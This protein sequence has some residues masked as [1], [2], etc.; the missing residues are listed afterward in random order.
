MA[1]YAELYELRQ[2]PDLL[3]RTVIACVVAAEI[4]RTDA[5]AG[6][7][8]VDGNHSN[9]LIWARRV[10]ADPWTDSVRMYWGL[11]AANKSVPRANILTATDIVIQD[12]VNAHVDMFAI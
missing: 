3:N 12:Q 9:R 11:L 7:P 1:T 10:F 2:Y 4:I 6:T 8:W 5:D